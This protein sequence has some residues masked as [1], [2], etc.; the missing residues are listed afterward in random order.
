VSCSQA[1]EVTVAAEL[2]QQARQSLLC[3]VA[4]RL[5]VEDPLP[6]GLGPAAVAAQLQE[7]SQLA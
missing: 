6:R 5:G 3:L 1:V 2:V 4:S 7:V